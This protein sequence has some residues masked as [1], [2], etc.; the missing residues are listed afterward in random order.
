MSYS[1]R[2]PSGL[3]SRM[4]A[5]DERAWAEIVHILRPFV[6]R[7]ITN[8]VRRTADHEDLFQEVIYKVFS[9]LN[10]F[11]GHAPF[12][13]WVSRLTRNACHDW[14]RRIKC[15]PLISYSDLPDAMSQI[16]E[17]RV[18]SQTEKYAGTSASTHDFISQLMNTLN[19]TEQ[20]VIRLFHL[21]E[22]SAQ[23]ISSLTG[24]GISKIKVTA[25][26]ARRKLSEQAKDFSWS[27]QMSEERVY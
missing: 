12:I 13:H 25:M 8:Q 27:D 16:I 21:E 17:N 24:Y 1:T 4:R 5:H 7:I 10:Q 2:I 18:S 14:Q 15:R 20:I 9:K 6:L 11:G 22:K 23:E 26:R 19:P 3:L